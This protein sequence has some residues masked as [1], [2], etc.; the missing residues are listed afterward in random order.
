MTLIC[1]I[2]FMDKHIENLQTFLSFYSFCKYIKM[3]SQNVPIKYLFIFFQSTLKCYCF[4]L[5]SVLVGRLPNY[6]DQ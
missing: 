3:E 6:I 2:F 4:L 1:I 5:L